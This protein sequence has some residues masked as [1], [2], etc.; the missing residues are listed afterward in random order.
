MCDGQRK[1]QQQPP[2]P[3]LELTSRII[4]GPAR[5]KPE[6]E[7]GLSVTKMKTRMIIRAINYTRAFL[8]VACKHVT[9]QQLNA[10][11]VTLI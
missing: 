4:Y 3:V 9:P 2:A 7:L 8:L 1:C 5:R 11:S 10:N 6:L